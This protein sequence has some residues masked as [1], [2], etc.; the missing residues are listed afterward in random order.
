M[1]DIDIQ[2]DWYFYPLIALMFGWPGLL[3]GGFASGYLW[4]RHRVIG[5]LLGALVGVGLWDTGE[6]FL[7]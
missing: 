7:R 6:F 4:R 5:A 2:F 1:S 3:L